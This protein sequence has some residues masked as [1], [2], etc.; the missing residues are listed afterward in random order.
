[1]AQ[2]LRGETR[3]GKPPA[4]KQARRSSS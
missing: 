1:M 4:T 3:K 2:R